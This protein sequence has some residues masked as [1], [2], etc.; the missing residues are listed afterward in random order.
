MTAAGAG[1]ALPVLHAGTDVRAQP[2]ADQRSTGH[3][4]VYLPPS[5]GLASSPAGVL[6]LALPI[7]VIGSNFVTAWMELKDQVARNRRVGGDE[8]VISYIAI[9]FLVAVDMS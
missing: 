6:M 8:S 4:L 1:T 3:F 9:V 5:N 7:S 2:F